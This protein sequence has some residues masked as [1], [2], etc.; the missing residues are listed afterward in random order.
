ML[1][2][3]ARVREQLAR[4]P[5]VYRYLHADGLPG[6]EG[7]FTQCGFWVVDALALAGRV[8]EAH[9][10]YAQLLGQA[11]DVG[12][13]SE[14]IDP[15]TGRFLGNFPQGLAHLSLIRTG[16]LL[17]RLT[18]YSNRCALID[19]RCTKAYRP[20]SAAHS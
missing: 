11:N 15:A 12:L 18:G 6:H 16:L 5:L 13:L 9:A 1:S 17:A 20:E 7:A 4:G 10:L 2:T 14:E 8:D 19:S 3:L